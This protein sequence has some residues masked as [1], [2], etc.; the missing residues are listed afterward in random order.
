MV[1]LLDAA[2]LTT[3]WTAEKRRSREQ[4]WREAVS[5]LVAQAWVGDE[6]GLTDLRGDTLQKPL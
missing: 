6:S 1:V 4:L 2:G 3:R 5:G